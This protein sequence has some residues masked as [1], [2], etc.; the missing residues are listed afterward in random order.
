MPIRVLHIIGSLGLGGAQRCLKQ[1]IEYNNDPAIEHYVYPLRSQPL[2]IPIQGNVIQLNYPHY[3]PRKFFAIFSLCRKYNIDIIHA[4]LHKPALAALL[5]R[6]FMTTPVV[7]HEHGSIAIEGFQYSLYR[8]LLK[9]LRRQA[10]LYIAVSN[11][12]AKDLERCSSI[13]R[14]SIKVVYNAVD[15]KTFTFDPYKRKSFRDQLGITDSDIVIGY[16]GRL[17]YE[18]GPDILL[19]AFAELIKKNP[20]FLLVF[21]G[22][23]NMEKSLHA[24]AAVFGIGHRVKFLGFRQDI[25][26]VLNIFDIGCIPS[27]REAFGL[28]AIEMMSMKIPVIASHVGCFGEILTDRQNALILKA[29]TPAHICQ[30]IL[31]LVEDADLRQHLTANA[32]SYVQQFS[33]PELVSQIHNIY[34]QITGK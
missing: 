25:A 8:T 28:A 16:A 14:R 30:S 9:I 20:A 29:N 27:R 32:S 18:K 34:R 21:A 1:I 23:G 15:T 11:S 31:Q 7:V 10:R 4:H 3:D 19:D 17:S 5:A 22:D 33:V 6:Y 2:A 13:P 24:R 26:D 12:V